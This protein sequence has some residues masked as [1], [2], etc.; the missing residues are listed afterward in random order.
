MSTQHTISNSAPTVASSASSQ[1]TAVVE[2][3]F[4][5]RNGQNHWVEWRHNRPAPH[6]HPYPVVPRYPVTAYFPAGP[7]PA[8]PPPIMHHRLSSESTIRRTGF[9]CGAMPDWGMHR[10]PGSTSHLKGT[11]CVVLAIALIFIVVLVLG[12][13]SNKQDH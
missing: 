6:H 13:V 12:L 5:V 4:S 7:H 1:K 3:E 10:P 8:E 11:A 9:S 2:S